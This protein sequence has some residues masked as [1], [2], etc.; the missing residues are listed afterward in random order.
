MYM[1]ACTM[2]G[3]RCLHFCDISSVA[4]DA[5]APRTPFLSWAETDDVTDDESWGEW[6][7][8]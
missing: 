8:D 3:S 4:A 2:Q 7:G 6:K 1:H 5:R